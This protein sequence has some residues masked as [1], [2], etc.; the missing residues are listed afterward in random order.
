MFSPHEL[1]A[2]IGFGRMTLR[3][4]IESTEKNPG[5]SIRIASSAS[6]PDGKRYARIQ[7]EHLRLLYETRKKPNRPDPRVFLEKGLSTRALIEAGY[8]VTVVRAA[9]TEL[10]SHLK[11]E[12]TRLHK[13]YLRASTG[14]HPSEEAMRELTRKKV[15]ISAILNNLEE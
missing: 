3:D 15:R 4:A 12:Y 6:T 5:G 10:R 11:H 8:P 13:Q 2:S 14:R 7:P 1:D 9:L